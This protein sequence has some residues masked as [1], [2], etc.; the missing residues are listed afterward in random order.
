M[1]EDKIH[2]WKMQLKVGGEWWLDWTTQGT[3][4]AGPYGAMAWLQQIRTATPEWDLRVV[5]TLAEGGNH[6]LRLAN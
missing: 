6:G 1:P 3:I 2:I 5:P 4:W